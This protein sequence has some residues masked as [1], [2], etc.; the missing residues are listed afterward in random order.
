[1]APLGNHHDSQPKNAISAQL[2]DTLRSPTP[3]VSFAP[4][5]TYNS[6]GQVATAVAIADVNNDGKTDL[7]VT[8]A[9]TNPTTCGDGEVGVLLGNGDGTFQTA[10]SYDSGGYDALYLVVADVN[11]DGNLDLLVAN[12]CVN[13]SCTSTGTVTLLLGRGDGT[14]QSP[15]TVANYAGHNSYFSIALAD[16][17]GDG[18]PDLL[19]SNG[20]TTFSSGYC[21]NA[22]Q[23]GVSLGNGDGTFQKPVS[24]NTG[25]FYAIGLSVG[26][27][28]GDGRPDLITANQCS[29]ISPC[30]D[31][32]V[33]VLLGNGD[34]T[35]ATAE[36]YLSGG[37]YAWA[38]AVA[39]VNGDKKLDLLISNQCASSSNCANG[40]IG[41][42]LGNGDGTFQ[43]AV[44][45]GSGGDNPSSFETGDLNGDG[46]PDIA[47]ANSCTPFGTCTPNADGVVGVL[48]GNGDGT[49][50][51]PVVYDSG[52]LYADGLAVGD[53]NGDGKPDVVVANY[54]PPSGDGG[55]LGVLLNTPTSPTKTKLSSSPDA[56]TYGQLVALTATVSSRKSGTPTGTVTFYDGTAQLGTSALIDQ[57]AVMYIDALT[58]GAH[59]LTALYSG[60]DSFTQSVSAIRVQKVARSGVSISLASSPNPS[61]VGQSVTFTAVVSGILTVPAGSV[62]FKQGKNVLGTVSLANGQA[63]FTMAFEKAGTFSIVASYSGDQNHL[64]RNSKPVKQLVNR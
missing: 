41:V 7:I 37:Q 54:Y 50:Q 11:G 61:S 29:N 58:V 33:G 38:G 10:V 3:G 43:A 34:G 26:D 18:K 22:G 23:V 4:T 16:V 60:D 12:T 28:N 42:L 17:N 44:A 24:Y 63:D 27:L 35:F 15:T 47:V 40:V 46:I 59:P 51:A 13:S 20:C 32:L 48:L 52:A 21:T 62:T 25:G 55:I 8:N 2:I 53:L 30:S 64:P 45:Y 49:F 36:T 1:M 19:M 56:S 31:G 57:T 39:D 6:G 9:C 5:V 14:F